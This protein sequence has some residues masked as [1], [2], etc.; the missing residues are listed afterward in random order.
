[1]LKRKKLLI[2]L[3]AVAVL[4]V[5]LLIWTIWANTALEL[6]TYTIVDPE[7]P[8]PFDG[9]RIAHISD[10]HNAEMGLGNEK[11]LQMLAEAQPN[12]IVIT[13]DM[14]D[15]R[16]TDVDVALLFASEA[17]KIAPCYYITGNHEMDLSKEDYAKLTEGL[18][19]RGV[20]M[21]LDD[22]VWFT[23]VGQTICLVGHGWGDTQNVGELTDFDGY[24]I[25]LSHQPEDFD[26]YVDAG[27]DLV[28]SGHSHGGQ[29]R[30]PFIGGLYA[31]G[32]GLF[33]EYDG[34]LYSK[35]DT[36]MVVSRGIGNS[37]FPLRFN[38]RPELVLIE[39]KCS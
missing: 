27:Y 14:V 18:T 32:Q 22:E 21:L 1:M 23:Y 37:S 31:P 30:L 5:A 15:A 7:I 29:F 16:H 17:V 36:T 2:V 9:F 8:E 39:L 19:K 11:L 13:G 12:I 28:L 35:G 34:G 33:P 3:S 26:N 4:L 25:L 10:L 6:T 38:N 24:K 20:T